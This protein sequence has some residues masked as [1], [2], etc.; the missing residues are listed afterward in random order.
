MLFRSVAAWLAAL[1]A[2]VGVGIIAWD[3]LEGGKLIGILVS[4]C[5]PLGFAGNT[6]ALRRYRNVDMVP[7]ICVGGFLTFFAAGFIGFFAGHR[8]GGFDVSLRTMGLL[9][10]MGLLQLAIP[11]VF[12]VKGSKSVPAV[13]L[14]LIVMLDAVINPLWPW[15][16][17]GEI[18]QGA[19]YIGGTIVISAVVISIFGGRWVART[20]N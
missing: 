6:L 5:F 7:A 4:L 18:P 19:A 9:A 2:L 20:S 1:L 17:V 12:F 15:L 3:G 11:L 13:T 16:F 10:I 14:A 8:G